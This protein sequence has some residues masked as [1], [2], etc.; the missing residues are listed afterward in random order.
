MLRMNATKP[1]RWKKNAGGSKQ[2]EL[3]YR[4]MPACNHSLT[5]P[6]VVYGAGCDLMRN[7]STPLIAPLSLGI[8]LA[9]YKKQNWIVT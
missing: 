3:L 1:L 9:H 8:D 5:D 2:C 6:M 4:Q 7:F